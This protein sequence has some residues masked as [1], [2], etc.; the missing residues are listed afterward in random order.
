MPRA[1]R[2]GSNVEPFVEKDFYLEQFRGRTVLIAVTPAAAAGRVDLRPLAGTVAE[3]ARNETRT[4]VWW[5]AVGQPG[6]R[7]LLAALGRARGGRKRRAPA[8]V[9]RLEPEASADTVRAALWG[10]TPMIGIFR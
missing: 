6:E 8:P 3:L 10:M 1:V 9:L 2:L 4:L 7:R 5:P